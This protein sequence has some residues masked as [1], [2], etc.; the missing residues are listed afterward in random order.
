MNGQLA[1]YRNQL[2]VG[3]HYMLLP[4]RIIAKCAAVPWIFGVHVARSHVHVVQEKQLEFEARLIE[5]SKSVSVRLSASRSNVDAFKHRW[6]CGSIMSMLCTLCRGAQERGGAGSE[7]K[8]RSASALTG[9][10]SI[11]LSHSDIACWQFGLQCV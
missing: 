8:V 9:C 10:I 11:V 3:T 7:P 6:V 4:V 5:F 2:C 1:S